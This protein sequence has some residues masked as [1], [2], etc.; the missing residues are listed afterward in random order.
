MCWAQCFDFQSIHIQEDNDEDHQDQE[1]ESFEVSLSGS[2]KN[3][4][5][6]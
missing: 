5:I 1:V 6:G 3:R 2:F 4:H